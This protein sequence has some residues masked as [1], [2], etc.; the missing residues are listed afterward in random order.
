MSGHVDFG[1][2]FH[3]T[4]PSVGNDLAVFVLRVKAADRATHFAAAAHGGEIRPPL[5]L[6]PE[7]LI[8]G[9][10]E[11][12]PV[13]LL[14]RDEIDV[15]LHVVDGE[16]MARDIEHRPPPGEARM[17]LHVQ[18]GHHDRTRTRRIVLQKRGQDLSQR[19][20]PI[21]QSRRGRRLQAERGR[22]HVDFV[23]FVSRL[24]R[25]PG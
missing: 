15:A 11:M 5:D 4:V 1:H 8:V 6:D 18:G 7:A 23:G 20:H 25:G 22:T 9:Q 16:E 12:E 14:K 3:E 24:R 17:I 2:D 19:L 10:V 21:E 13:H